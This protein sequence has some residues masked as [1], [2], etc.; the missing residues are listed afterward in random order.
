MRPFTLSRPTTIEDAVAASTTTCAD[1]MAEGDPL[2]PR[3]AI[4]KG[5]GNDLLDLMKEGLVSPAQLID[6]R[7]IPGMSDFFATED[8]GVRIGGGVVLADLVG[9]DLLVGP[10]RAL[11]EA[12][13]HVAHPQIRATATLAGSLIQRPR[14]YYFRLENVVDAKKGGTGFPAYE[15]R[16]ELSAIFENDRCPHVHPSTLAT[17]LLAMGATVEIAGRGGAR[18]IPVADFFTDPAEDVIRENVLEAGEIVT[19][20]LLPPLEGYVSW[21]IKQG[22]RDSYD[23]AFVDVAVVGRPEGGGL[24]DARVA[25]GSV[26]PRPRRAPGVEEILA[27]GGTPAEAAE[28]ATDGATPLSRNAFKL[29]MLRA[30]TRRTIEGA[31]A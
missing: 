27:A 9:S 21:H 5:A 7:G 23:W 31:L 10:Y 2:T 29:P 28:R 24:A 14:D 18:A 13:S 22:Q 4:F 15:G 3:G 30:V 16:N 26:A 1:L 12:A 25:L 19:A 17:V 6:V 20:I 8:G 11:S